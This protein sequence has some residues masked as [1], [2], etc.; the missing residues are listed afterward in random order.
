MNYDDLFRSAMSVWSGMHVVLEGFDLWLCGLWIPG[1][2]GLL[3]GRGLHPGQEDRC[4]AT[5][6]HQRR[7]GAHRQHPHGHRQDQDLRGPSAG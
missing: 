5:Q 6:E 2:A 3:L 7:K 1:L 4:R